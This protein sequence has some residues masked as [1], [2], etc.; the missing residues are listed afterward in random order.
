VTDEAQWRAAV[1]LAESAFGPVSLLVNNAGIVVWGTVA[2]MTPEDFRR[3]IDVNLTGA[4]LGMHTAIP[5]LRRSREATGKG[6]VIVNISSTAGLMGYAGINAYVASKWGVRG[7]TKAAALELAGDGIRVMSIHPG[8][9]RTPMTADLPDESTLRQAIPRL[10]EPEE[11]SK[12]L[13]FMAAD[14]TF[15][16]GSEWVVDGGAALGP[17]RQ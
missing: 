11:V 17:M 6:G 2:D 12:L 16:T 10:G 14:A 1:D 5:S 7:L 4:Y 9:V 15:S 3:V 13:L 8:P